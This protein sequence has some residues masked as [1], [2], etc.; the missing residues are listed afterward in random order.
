MRIKNRNINNKKTAKSDKVQSCCGNTPHGAA[1]HRLHEDANP[2]IKADQ[3][4]RIY[5][6]AWEGGGS[7][8]GGA[9][10]RAA[11]WN[12]K[13][14]NSR[15]TATT[16]FFARQTVCFQKS[17]AH[18]LGRSCSFFAARAG[19]NPRYPH[20]IFTI[21]LRVAYERAL[22]PS[23]PIFMATRLRGIF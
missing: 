14:R 13:N 9:C 17:T 6:A 16:T 2:N 1:S 12:G 18:K 19:A 20:W 23:G 15:F 4:R 7:A 8:S 10:Q 21:A 22:F 3:Q 5:P 11:S